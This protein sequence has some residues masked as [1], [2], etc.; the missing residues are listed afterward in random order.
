MQPYT[1]TRETSGELLRIV[2]PMLSKHP[3]GFTPISYA[4]WYEYAAGTNSGL[5]ADLD[6]LI[7][8]GQKLDDERAWVLYEKHISQRDDAAS[9]RLRNE[10]ERMML[11]LG[12]TAATTGEHA[13]EFGAS[14]DGFGKQ[15]TPGA[16][17]EML[18]NSVRAMLEKTEQMTVRTRALETQLRESSREVD[19]LRSELVRAKGEALTDALTGI[20][21]RR[22]FMNSVE[23]AQ[24]SQEDGLA[25]TCLI[26]IDID[27]FKHCNDTYGHLFGDKVIRNLAH[28]L[29]RLIKG[30]DV[31]ARMGGEEFLVFL[32]G[33]PIDGAS[34]LAETLRTTVAAG[35][36]T[37]PA[38]GDTGRITISLGVTNY[39]ADETLEEFIARADQALYASKAGGRDRVTLAPS[40][41]TA[42][43]A[44]ISVMAAN[45][46][47]TG[48]TPKANVLDLTRH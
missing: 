48:K 47:V 17:P 1:E 25:G 40:S 13:T 12:Q 15:L 30:Q 27:H 11:E 34:K 29:K 39:R 16:N 37:N 38:N 35:R 9:M 10:L 41:S 42:K 19:Y 24:A 6:K 4:I 21:N 7:D 44:D 43:S 45:R 32:P 36:I 46:S 20:A 3:A 22:G 33:T 23:L 31:A 2:L 18:K 8:A 26:A 5:K 28:V 14:L